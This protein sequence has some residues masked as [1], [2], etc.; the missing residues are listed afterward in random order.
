MLNAV[1]DP[2]HLQQ[3]A[4]KQHEQSMADKD[5]RTASCKCHVCA[6]AA[7]THEALAG[8][9]CRV[10]LPEAAQKSDGASEDH[11]LPEGLQSEVQKPSHLR[12]SL[13]ALMYDS[14]PHFS[15]LF[16][17]HAAAAPTDMSAGL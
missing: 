2:I 16:C 9:A 14:K 11:S 15:R 1:L 17:C 13:T 5:I 6:T 12:L 4:G 8:A 10:P 3:E 7:A